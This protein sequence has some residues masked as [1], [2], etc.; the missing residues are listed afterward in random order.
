MFKTPRPMDFKYFPKYF[1]ED[2]FREKNKP[3]SFKKTGQKKYPRNAK[4]LRG[5]LIVMGLVLILIYV[6]L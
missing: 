1:T 6:L 4:S 3:Y 2:V 5:Y